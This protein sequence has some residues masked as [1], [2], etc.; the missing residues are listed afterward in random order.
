M[1]VCYGIWLLQFYCVY[2]GD[3]MKELI[4]E[5]WF[6]IISFILLFC[7]GFIIDRAGRNGDTAMVVVAIIGILADVVLILTRGLQ[8]E[9]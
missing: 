4:S 6:I 5:H 7:F 8:N 1:Y 9:S 3:G 2:R